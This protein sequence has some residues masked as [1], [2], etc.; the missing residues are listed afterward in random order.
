MVGQT[1][2]CITVPPFLD[3]HMPL[4]EQWTAGAATSTTLSA[5]SKD[6]K[7]ATVGD[8]FVAALGQFDESSLKANKLGGAMSN[9]VYMCCFTGAG[10]AG[11][12]AEQR[13]LLLRL[14]GSSVE[15][16][17]AAESAAL[18]SRQQEIAR[19]ATFSAAGQAPRLYATFANGRLEEWV[20]GETLT[21]PSMRSAPVSRAVAAALARFHE[22]AT[23]STP[24]EADG[25]DS[26]WARLR[27]W[28]SIAVSLHKD[29]PQAVAWPY[30]SPAG[31][32]ECAALQRGTARAL[33]AE[34]EWLYGQLGHL[35][36][37]TL[38]HNDLQHGNIIWCD[39]RATLVDFEYAQYSA[40]AYDVANHWCE[41]AAD[42]GGDAAMLDF[43]G[44]YPSRAERVA[45]SAA[46]LEARSGTPV[47]GAAAA[48]AFADC[49]ERFALSSHLLWALWGLVSASTSTVDFDF[50]SYA[51]ARL[52]QYARFKQDLF[53]VAAGAE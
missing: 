36:E 14:Y 53:G 43:E 26:L 24:R 35:A 12:Q 31:S 16:G 49:A 29:L 18:L 46:Y 20:P 17:T 41:W 30:S 6:P 27:R 44:R 9:H 45:F 37:D 48:E 33:G 11:Q 47:A 23:A 8:I 5:T 21:S 34:V 40:A 39:G 28:L 1:A 50:V 10:E 2:M 13:R 7:C 22:G 15:P 52:R 25:A 42:Y 4:P 3:V 38:C 19:F 32:E 51:D